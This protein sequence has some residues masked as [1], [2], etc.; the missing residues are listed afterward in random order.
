MSTDA[1]LTDK[2]LRL[3]RFIEQF[4]HDYGY[5]P[6]FAEISD[7]LG[8]D[9][10]TVH[11]RCKRLLKASLLAANWLRDPKSGTMVQ[12]QRSIRLT[13]EGRKAIAV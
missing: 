6:S 2:Q 4:W 8:V 7:G 11:E 13:E 10:T 5:G 9:T 12:Q 3:L 1:K